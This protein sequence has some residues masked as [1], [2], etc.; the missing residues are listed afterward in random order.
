M[1]KKSFSFSKLFLIS[2]MSVFLITF[3]VYPGVCM[4]VELE[5]MRFIEDESLRLAWNRQL[6]IFIFN[7]FDTL[8]RWAG[9]KQ[10]AKFKDL[11]VIVMTYCRSIFIAT[12]V[13]TALNKP[14]FWLFGKGADWFKMLNMILF[15][16]TNGYCSTVCAVR[17]P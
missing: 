4:K 11:V 14:P 6:F 8:G 3:V 15:A 12:F 17:G 2:L 5:F 9:D 13:L 7:I 10:F 16:L 1:V